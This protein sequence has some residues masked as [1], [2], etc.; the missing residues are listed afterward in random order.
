ME[1][2]KV[3]AMPGVP[4]ERGL[5][6]PKGDSYEIKGRTTSIDDLPAAKDSKTAIN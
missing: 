4:G 2:V 1:V 6:G 3:V 5:Q